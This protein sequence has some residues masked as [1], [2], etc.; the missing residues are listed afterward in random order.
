MREPRNYLPRDLQAL[1]YLNALEARDLESVASLWDEASRDPELEALLVAVD[2][3]L[4]AD[5]SANSNDAGSVS[6]RQKPAGLSDPHRPGKRR[7][8]IWVG[9]GGAVAA[10][11][12]LAVLARSVRNGNDPAGSRKEDDTVKVTPGAPDNSARNFVPRQNWQFPDEEDGP[13]FQWPLPQA[14]RVSAL[15][16]FSPDP[17]D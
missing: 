14:S 9:T 5:H 3:T 12:L 6:L 7:W 10:A 8:V 16:S 4:F 15:T 2:R 13:R 11:C 1:Q 17:L